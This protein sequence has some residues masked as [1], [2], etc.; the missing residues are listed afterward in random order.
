MCYLQFHFLCAKLFMSFTLNDLLL[1]VAAVGK[2]ASILHEGVFI[3]HS[4]ASAF[5]GTMAIAHGFRITKNRLGCVKAPEV[6]LC[7]FCLEHPL[8]SDYN[9][10]FILQF[11]NSMQSYLS[12]LCFSVMAAI[13]CSAMD[14]N[15]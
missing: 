12:R 1:V 9:L 6:F 13:M 2:P 4:S 7:Q 3:S 10:F 8:K 14:F 11:S 15:A 5:F